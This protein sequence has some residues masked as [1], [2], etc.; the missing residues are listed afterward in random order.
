MKKQ[1]A[2]EAELRFA[3]ELTRKGWE[4]FLPYGE[5]NPI[6]ILAHKKGDYLKLQVKATKKKE[7]SS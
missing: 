6:D 1:I 7:R 4:I 3:A 2:R 5:D